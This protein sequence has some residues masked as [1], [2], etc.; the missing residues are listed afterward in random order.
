MKCRNSDRRINDQQSHMY[1]EVI[2]HRHQV[3]SMM[4]YFPFRIVIKAADQSI[5]LS[6]YYS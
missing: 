6:R 5:Q 1:L 3:C 2:S 4:Q